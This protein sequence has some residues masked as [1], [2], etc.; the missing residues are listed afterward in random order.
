METTLRTQLPLDQAERARQAGFATQMIYLATNDPEI[1][2]TRALARQA[3]GGRDVE[4]SNVR[5]VHERSLLNLRRALQELD[6]VEAYDSSAR[7][8]KPS[9]Q[10]VASRGAVCLRAEHL[11]TWAREALASLEH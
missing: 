4:S 11:E 6:R 9:F 3:G 8:T 5:A 10:F 7:E 2:V 1:N